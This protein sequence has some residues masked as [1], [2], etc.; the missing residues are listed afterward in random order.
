MY[1]RTVLAALTLTPAVRLNRRLSR[2]DDDEIA[3]EI[4]ETNSMG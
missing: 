1:I 4:R 3:S 2:S